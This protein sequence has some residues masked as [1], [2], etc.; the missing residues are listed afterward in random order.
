MR[1]QGIRY[2]A[3]IIGW[4]IDIIGSILASAIALPILAPDAGDPQVLGQRLSESSSL[5]FALLLLGLMFDLLGGYVAARL[6]P[7]EE[8]RNAIAVGLLSG[9][10]GALQTIGAT[11]G[12]PLWLVVAG[13]ILAI[14]FAAFGGYLRMPPPPSLP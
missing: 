9:V 6:A 2:R 11:D 8:L 4:A 5:A 10:S 1:F 7:G 12:W 3:V 14:P 13:P